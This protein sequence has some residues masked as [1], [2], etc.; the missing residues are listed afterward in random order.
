MNV[1]TRILDGMFAS[2]D[3]LVELLSATKRDVDAR[4]F[5]ALSED[6]ETRYARIVEQVLYALKSATN[7]EKLKGCIRELEQSEFVTTPKQIAE[8][9]STMQRNASP[10]KSALLAQIEQTV[11]LAHAQ[12][13]SVYPAE[14]VNP[15]RLAYKFWAGICTLFLF[16]NTFATALLMRDKTNFARRFAKTEEQIAPTLAQFRVVSE[17]EAGQQA[18]AGTNMLQHAPAFITTRQIHTNSADTT[19]SPSTPLTEASSGNTTSPTPLPSDDELMLEDVTET[20]PT[21]EL[22]T[23]SDPGPC[24]I[25]IWS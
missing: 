8:I 13:N 4:A 15:R 19:I 5:M 7:D 1:F 6:L 16:A 22:R 3:R 11:W 20:E 23:Q 24:T 2:W 21:R 9:I 14:K 12:V 25:K 10:V 17:R 18:D